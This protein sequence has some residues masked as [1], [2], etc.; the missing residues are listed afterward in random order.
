MIR[1][2]R[3]ALSVYLGTALASA[4]LAACVPETAP[5]TRPGLEVADVPNPNVTIIHA[6]R[7]RAFAMRVKV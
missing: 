2:S 3:T 6:A 7:A 5:P 1:S 4:S